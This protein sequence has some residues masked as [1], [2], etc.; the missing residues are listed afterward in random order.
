MAVE[1]GVRS[2]AM[3]D[4]VCFSVRLSGGL[5]QCNRTEVYWMPG[6][7][8]LE[9]HSLEVYLVNAQHTKNV[10]ARKSDVQECQ[11]LRKLHAFGLLNNSFQPTDK[12][13]IARTL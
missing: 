13:R 5:A 10:P 2:V 4:T 3:R 9:Q 7:E 1:K 12:I 8:V 6:F 11:W